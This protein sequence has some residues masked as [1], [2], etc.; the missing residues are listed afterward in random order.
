MS[1]VP[2]ERQELATA[3]RYAYHD[4]ACPQRAA[5]GAREACAMWRVGH[6]PV[7]A[8]LA[9]VE[10]LESHPRDAAGA[11]RILHDAVCSNGAECR[12]TGHPRTQ[13]VPVRVLRK[14]LA[15]RPMMLATEPEM[16]PCSSSV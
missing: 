13:T 5:C 1:A 12:D 6:Q 2:A 16:P 3:Y 7:P 4:A 10:H 9:A 11:R 15:G 8:W 14:V